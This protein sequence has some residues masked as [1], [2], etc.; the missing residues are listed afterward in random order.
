MTPDGPPED[1]SPE[2]SVRAR[3]MSPQK[4]TQAK[5]GADTQTKPQTAPAEPNA[6]VPSANV[7][8]VRIS[9]SQVVRTVV[10][11]LLTA[12]VVL[13]ALFLLWQVRTF[14]GWFVI[15][16]LSGG[17]AQPGRQ[18]APAASQADQAPPRHSAHLL[19]AGGGTAL[20]GGDP[21][22]RTGGPNQG[23]A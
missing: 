17:G 21:L 9:P 22:A 20:Y 8:W 23:T 19:G 12:A 11:A 13:G 4:E 5:P 14:V 10:I 2:E 15:A 3:E 6:S 18:L 16:L 1:G 7:V